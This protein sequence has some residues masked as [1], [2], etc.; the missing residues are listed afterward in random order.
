MQNAGGLRFDTKN[1]AF[2]Y[3]NELMDRLHNWAVA[4]GVR[5][6]REDYLEA[7]CEILVDVQFT[8]GRKPRD[9]KLVMQVIPLVDD[10]LQ[11]SG[12]LNNGLHKGGSILETGADYCLVRGASEVA[13]R[14]QNSVAIPSIVWLKKE[15]IVDEEL[16]Y[17]NALPFHFF[18]EV[19]RV[20]SE[21][22]INSLSIFAPKRDSGSQ[23]AWSR[24][25][26]NCFMMV[27]A[28][29]RIFGGNLRLSWSL[30]T[31]SLVFGSV[32]VINS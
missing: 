10:N 32:L 7:Q 24:A 19:F 15:A 4:Q 28:R 21:R 12:R 16:I 31:F 11:W 17:T 30:T 20:F 22:E 18:F 2:N 27:D 3:A 6:P 23:K 13:H 9:F 5:A 1:D 25:I 14:P 29:L 8:S 26:L